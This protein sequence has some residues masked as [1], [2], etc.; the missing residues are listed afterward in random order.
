MF[1]MPEAQQGRSSP[2]A[3]AVPGTSAA[4]TFRWSMISPM[5]SEID[6]FMAPD[7]PQ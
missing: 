6:S 4:V 2:S 1:R 3:H 5:M 7:W